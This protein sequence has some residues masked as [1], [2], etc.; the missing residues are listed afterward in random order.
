MN[1]QDSAGGLAGRFIALPETRQLDVL[2]GL[3]ERRGAK[4]L[5]C[6]L[7]A[8][9]DAPDQGR[10]TAWLHRFIEDEAL[11]DLIVL[12]GEGM[13]RL[14]AASDRAGLHEAF[15]RRLGQVRKITRG[16]KPGG[17]LRDLGLASEVVVQLATTAGVIAALEGL[18]FDTGYIALQLYGEE[19]NLPLQNYLRGRGLEP[20]AVSPYIYADSSDERRVLDLIDRLAQGEMDAIAFT[21][22]TQIQRLFGVARAHAREAGLREGLAGSIVAA[23][24]PVVANYLAEMGVR[25]DVMPDERFF[26]R[27]LADALA[28]RMPAQ[29]A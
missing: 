23:V 13:R 27:P 9:L 15:A 5:R 6:P 21:S 8:I 18:Q 26:M 29:K 12:T 10:V 11:H 1:D 7:V 14:I 16:P 28:A 20:V 3:L 4:V 17:A 24:G 19:P 2:A 22:R 25:V